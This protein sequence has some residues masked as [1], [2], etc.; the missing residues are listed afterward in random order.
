MTVRAR[1]G[2]LAL[3]FGLLSVRASAESDA[4][5]PEYAATAVVDRGIEATSTARLEGEQVRALPLRTSEDALR[6]V[7][8]VLLVQHASEGKGHQFLLRGF[9]AMHG[10]DLEL[11]VEGI[12]INEAS[13]V[14]GQGYVDLA[15]LLPEAIRSVEVVK[16]PFTS[17]QGAFALAGSARY[18]LGIPASDRG[19]RSS[20]TF[21]TTNRQRGVMTY[22]P[23]AGDGGDFIAA[24]VLHDDGFGVNRGIDRSGILG[25][26][27]L[28]D[29][30]R[31]GSLALLGAAS[32]AR[33]GLGGTVR[34]EDVVA[35]RIGFFDV[36]DPSAR[37]SSHRLLAGLSYSLEEDDSVLRVHGH[38]SRRGLRLREN[39]TGFLVDPIEGDR[40]LQ[41]HEASTFG[42]GIDHEQRLTRRVTL[43]AGAGVRADVLD[44]AQRQ[45]DE[46]DVPLATE[47]S[48]EATQRFSHA[49]LGMRLAPHP[50]WHV[51]TGVRGDVARFEVR[52]RQTGEETTG[53]VFAISPR[54][55]SEWRLLP[56][57]RLA[58]AYGRGFRPP[59]ARA[60]TRYRAP[61][62]GLA[63]D[64]FDGG[65]PA[66]TTSDTVELGVRTSPMPS[67]EARATSFATFLARESIYD[68][69]SGM[70]LELNA[71]RRVGAELELR[72]DPTPW[73]TLAA[74]LTYVHARFVR[75]GRPIPF[76]PSL[77]GGGRL[78]F[79]H[80]LG[81]RAGL[82]F[83]GFSPRPLPQGAR[84]AGVG[85]VDASLGYGHGM[86][87]W[88]LEL[89]NLLDLR[90]RAGE[91]H[92]A[93]HFRPDE[94][95][96]E[97][98]VLHYAAAPPF[99]ARLRMTV[100]Y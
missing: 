89:E 55:V 39:V 25:R 68:H 91:Y 20:V 18:R 26:V 31:H 17:E 74:D 38:V 100:T 50:K 67:L 80:P 48:L 71:T 36:Y 64:R 98:P 72:F 35:G 79:A 19:L 41:V 97:L 49:R 23:H 27:R 12:P 77:L 34:E 78:T 52:D 61:V 21:G 4:E 92:F 42:G 33:F 6:L 51:R 99:N 46:D 62:G 73:L 24:E 95:P 86:F 58:L 32:T 3:L 54:F 69:V 59:E 16:G 70:N 93:S 66:M 96:S 53:R 5:V 2:I 94:E 81:F 56:E 76:V 63:E 30:S 45:V 37:G 87:R 44:Q 88:D 8:G 47:R 14:H 85:W 7:P 28:F 57:T 13:N 9:D 82:R 84:G 15:F 43:D 40:R 83:F 29:S 60:F 22:S 90:V 1:A 75:S 10:A 11:E 65:R